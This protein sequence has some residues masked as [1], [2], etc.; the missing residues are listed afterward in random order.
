MFRKL[1]LSAAIATATLTGLAA[2]ASTAD[3]AAL[4]YHRRFEVLAERHGCWENR[5][6]YRH[7]SEAERV[8][9]HLRHE[10]FRVQIREF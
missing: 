10:G 2:T 5:G 3:A 4:G 8:A 9:R 6:T 1:I 7:R